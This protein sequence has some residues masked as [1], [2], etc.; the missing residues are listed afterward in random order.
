M[1]PLAD[2]YAG[3]SPYAFSFNDPVNFNDP[4][5]DEAVFVNGSYVTPHVFGGDAGGWGGGGRDGS[6]LSHMMQQGWTGVTYGGHEVVMRSGQAG[7][8][9][10]I[11]ER[12]SSPEGST[13]LGNVP[14]TAR[15]TVIP[16]F[17]MISNDTGVNG[18]NF[19]SM[20]ARGGAGLGYAGASLGALEVLGRAEDVLPNQLLAANGKFYSAAGRWPGN[21]WTGSRVAAVAATKAMRDA[22]ANAALKS[23]RPYAIAGKVSMYGG[24][25]LSATQLYYNGGSNKDV[26]KFAGS[27]ITTAIG[28]GVTYAAM[29]A[30]GGP[31][32][33]AVGLAVGVG[34]TYADATGKL[35][36]LYAGF[37]DTK[38]W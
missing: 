26:A 24:I 7:Y 37:D 6:T 20:F 29:G 8:F 36:W 28:Q 19:N 11:Y 18:Y 27:I 2:K 25:A 5:G 34:I 16:G 15:F 14:V 9:R 32:G 1:D 10:L 13:A 23:L 31:I 12:T 3:E 4:N 30:W 21:Q 17:A 35:D 22:A 38:H 33:M